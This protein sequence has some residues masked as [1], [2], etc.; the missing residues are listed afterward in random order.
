MEKIEEPKPL[1]I[2][3]TKTVIEYNG[4]VQMGDASSAIIRETVVLVNGNQDT[5]P[6]EIEESNTDIV[7]KLGTKRGMKKD[8][9]S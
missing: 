6:L 4:P 9:L 1:E 8:E 2:T 7:E 3:P 5:K